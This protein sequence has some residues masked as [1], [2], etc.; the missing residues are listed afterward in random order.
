LDVYLRLGRLQPGE[1]AQA[2]GSLIA[3]VATE[4]Q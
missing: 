4:V 1:D 2:G 3:P